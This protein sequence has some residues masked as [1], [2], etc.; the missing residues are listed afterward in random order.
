M[1]LL[2]PKSLLERQPQQLLQDHLIHVSVSHDQMDSR[3]LQEL[4]LVH[5]EALHA[6]GGR[7]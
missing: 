6:G 1:F 5:E 7:R 4:L 3:T 2:H